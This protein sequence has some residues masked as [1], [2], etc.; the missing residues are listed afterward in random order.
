[1]SMD[2]N[3]LLLF[4]ECVL[5]LANNLHKRLNTNV[6]TPHQTGGSILINQLIL[7]TASCIY[8]LCEY[9]GEND[10]SYLY[11]S[12]YIN[13]KDNYL[14][15][16]NIFKIAKVLNIP[17][18]NFINCL[19]MCLAQTSDQ[20]VSTIGF[21]LDDK[22]SMGKEDVQSIVN[23]NFN[24]EQDYGNETPMGKQ[25]VK[26]DWNN[27]K[28]HITNNKIVHELARITQGKITTIN[29]IIFNINLFSAIRNDLFQYII[30]TGDSTINGILSFLNKKSNVKT[31]N[32]AN[33]QVTEVTESYVDDIPEPTSGI[34]NDE[35]ESGVPVENDETE[36]V[37]PAA[38]DETESGVPAANVETK[39]VVPA[40]NVETKPVVPPAN[41]DT[42]SSVPVAN[43]EP[44]SANA[45]EAV[46]IHNESATKDN[47][48]N[49]KDILR[50]IING[51]G[52]SVLISAIILSTVIAGV[53]KY[54][55][56]GQLNI[57]GKIL[58]MIEI[59][60]IFNKRAVKDPNFSLITIRKNDE[61]EKIKNFV[62]ENNKRYGII[63]QS[64]NN[65][66]LIGI[67]IDLEKKV[68]FCYNPNGLSNTDDK[69]KALMSNINTGSTRLQWYNNGENKVE[70]KMLD[71]GMY[72]IY[73]IFHMLHKDESMHR[74]I[75]YFTNSIITDESIMKYFLQFHKTGGGSSI[76]QMSKKR[77]KVTKRKR[78]NKN[79]TKKRN[80][81]KRNTKK[82]N[83][84]KR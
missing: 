39:P 35:I 53:K 65:F 71:C 3:D 80:T 66:E 48:I 67:Y 28:F 76:R 50:H 1:M 16:P 61:F 30:N 63:V 5:K 72:A 51:F 64:E 23:S 34:A 4:K 47:I 41:V 13:M 36:P 2:D 59:N 17:D 42:E 37:V 10:K 57:E 8:V 9:I 77:R 81:R 70:N 62:F 24:G 15:D 45:N 38:N 46:P 73:F 44:V 84:K 60:D 22:I 75:E 27:A 14:R 12:S 82:R 58:T 20:R 43:F 31:D 69:I 56:N 25:V 78:H 40:A 49:Y 54:R 7:I 19:K 83:T 33:T 26:F 29:G 55:E 18:V 11:N 32:S 21:I 68:G 52:A 74:L 79:R 6:D